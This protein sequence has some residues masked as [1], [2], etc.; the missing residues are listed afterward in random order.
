MGL[1]TGHS[2]KPAL[3]NSSQNRGGKNRSTTSAVMPW[4]LLYC[5]WLQEFFL[6]RLLLLIN[7][8]CAPVKPQE[9]REWTEEALG[10]TSRRF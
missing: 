8:L 4:W 9:P 7:L 1:Q 3:H 6:M 5:A 10:D 2:R